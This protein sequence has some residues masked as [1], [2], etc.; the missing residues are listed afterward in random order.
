MHY[1]L[2]LL[3][4]ALLSL[5]S[6]SAAIIQY[7]EIDI[8]ELNSLLEKA[9]DN[10]PALVAQGLAQKESVARLDAANGAY[11]PRLDLG[12]QFGVTRTTYADDLFADEQRVGLGFGASVTRPLY[13]WGAIEATIEQARLDFKNEE[14]QRVFLLRQIK[15]TLRA[16]Y[17]TLLVN[18]ETL[19]SLRLRRQITADSI[20][21][22][23]AD[24]D[25]GAASLVESEQANLTLSQSLIDIEQLEAEQVRI[26]ANYRRNLGWDAPLALDK[27]VPTPDTAA[28]IAW[29][30]QTRA[31]GLDDWLKD[32][33]E[34][35]RRQNLV[36]RERQELIRV[37]AG[38]RPLFNLTGSVTQ[39]QRNTSVQNNVEA[40]S[41]FIGIGMTWNVFDGFT[42]AAKK[43]ETQLRERRLERQLE[44]YRG[45]LRAQSVVVVSQIGFIARQLQIDQRRA[46]LSAQSF[47]VQ[48]REAKEG[49]VSAQAFR[50]VQIAQNEVQQMAMRTRVRL[51]LAIND[52]L[53]LTLPAAVNL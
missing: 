29:V 7:P 52:Y 42:T 40:I 20:A 22:I 43:R 31:I 37:K 24:K 45:E 12:G 49:R 9:R 47:G 46:E 51:L 6:L 26:L 48:E 38:Q 28:V 2:R 11:Y 50:S 18:Q 41:Y 53:D 33:A 25:Q 27:P 17:L 30:E 15:R 21:R 39:E 16:D 4:F 14:L 36:A 10:A 5:G 3:A 1:P 23:Q 34:V 35:L 19:K 44:A 8:P 32:N 13:H